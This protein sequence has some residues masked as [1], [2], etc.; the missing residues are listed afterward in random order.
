MNLQVDVVYPDGSTSRVSRALLDVLIA[1]G[2][3]GGFRRAEGWVEL[4][5]SSARFRDYSRELCRLGP[6]RRAIWK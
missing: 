6:D 1:T 2:K 5:D 4:N 3:I